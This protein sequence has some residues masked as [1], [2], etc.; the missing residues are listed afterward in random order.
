MSEPG[1]VSEA[2]ARLRPPGELGGR[3]GGLS[4]RHQVLTLAAWPLLEQLMGFLVQSADIVIAGW[5]YRGG[6]RIAVMDAMGFSAYVGWLMMILQ[7]SVGVGVMAVVSR[8]AGARDQAVASSAL[9]QGLLV[10]FLTGLVSGISIRLL[11]SPML[12]IFPLGEAAAQFASEYLTMLVWMC[13]FVGV[14]LAATH[15]L[16]A[17]GDT[18]TPF[19][20]MVIVNCVNIGLSWLFVFGPEPIGGMGVSGLALGTVLAWVVGMVVVL[21]FL[22][23]RAGIVGDGSDGVELSLAF[24]PLAAGGGDDAT[25]SSCGSAAG[26]GD[27]GN[28]V[29][30]SYLASFRRGF[31]AGGVDGGA[32]DRAPGGVDEFFT[33]T[34]DRDGG[35]GVDGAVSRGEKSGDGEAGGADVLALRGVFDV[36]DGGAFSYDPGA[37]GGLHRAGR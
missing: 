11:I 12:S 13:P 14:M 31:G 10:G 15:A 25:D 8:A 26:G 22:F 35:G 23:F 20:A 9:G 34:G 16:R 18:R 2:K 3:L 29:D 33:G 28:V 17:I 24:V 21:G 1:P 4:L 7:G 30:Q 36:A 19:F 5:A 32:L 37:L 27:V 6:D